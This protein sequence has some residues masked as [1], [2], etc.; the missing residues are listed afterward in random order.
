MGFSTARRTDY[1]RW[2]RALMNRLGQGL[3]EDDRAALIEMARFMREQ[4]AQRREAPGDDLLSRLIEAEV[5]GERLSDDELVAHGVFL[6]AAGHETTTNLLGSI[7]DTLLERPAL[8]EQLHAERELIAPF[9]EEVL[10]LEAP[11]QS[12]C[13][14]TREPRSLHGADIPGDARV[15]F[16]LGA[17]GRDHEVFEAPDALDLE[18][19][20]ASRH[21]AFGYGNHLCLGAP[22]ARLEARIFTE[23]LLDRFVSMR[24]AG[25]AERWRST[26]VRG[27]HQLHIEVERR[28]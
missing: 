22:L 24:R 21:L 15:L 19:P 11:I 28:Q 26:V 4:V 20:N 23:G 2:S 16:S 25:P 14:T 6:L 1:R 9:I 13:R 12:I 3:S 10:R 18:R 27:F 17:S 5:E 8:F 7:V